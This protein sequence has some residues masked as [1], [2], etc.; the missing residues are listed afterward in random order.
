MAFLRCF[1]LFALLFPLHAY[2]QWTVAPGPS[3]AGSLFKTAFP[4]ATTGFLAA[5]NGD[6]FRTANGGASWSQ[7]YNEGMVTGSDSYYF[8]DIQFLSEQTGFAV[9]IDYWTGDFLILKTTNGGTSWSPF[10]YEFGLFIGWCNAVDFTDT[11]NGYVVGDFGLFFRTSNG[12]ATWTVTQTPVFSNLKAVDFVDSQNGFALS[13]D[14]HLLKTTNGGTS[15]Q[16]YYPQ[17][18][19]SF[20]RFQSA[21]LGFASGDGLFRTT[22]GGISW[23][24]MQSDIPF[25][26][27]DLEF[28]STTSAVALWNGNF[29][30]TN[31]ACQTWHLQQNTLSLPG[32]DD[33][34]GLYD[35]D[36]SSSTAGWA[37]GYKNVG[38]VVSALVMKTA[39]G[40]GIALNMNLSASYLPCPGSYP[41][42]A[43]ATVLGGTATLQW[44]IDGQPT[45][46]GAPTEILNGPWDSGYRAV[47]VDATQGNNTVSLEKYVQVEY[48]PTDN[49]AWIFNFFQNACIGDQV[50]LY[51]NFVSQD[52]LQLTLNGVVVDGPRAMTGNSQDNLRTSPLATDTSVFVLEIITPCGPV[53]LREIR[54]PARPL[55]DQS[56]P[57]YTEDPLTRCSTGNYTTITVGNTT[58][59]YYFRLFQDGQLVG[60]WPTSGGWGTTEIISG[61]FD[62]TAVFTVSATNQYGCVAFLHDSVVVQV[63][64]PEARFGINGANLPFGTPVGVNFEGKEATHLEW[65]FGPGA[66]PA[67]FSGGTPPAVQYSPGT[68]KSVISLAVEGPLGCRDTFERAIGFYTPGVPSQYWA[69]ESDLASQQQALILGQ[70]MTV[71]SQGNIYLDGSTDQVLSDPDGFGTLVASRAGAPAY[72]RE[73]TAGIFKYD[74]TGV[75]LWYLDVEG[76]QYGF[77]DLETTPDDQ[78]VMPF[79]HGSS[80]FLPSTDQKRVPFRDL[81]GTALCKYDQQ[82]RLLWTA[83]SRGCGQYGGAYA[84]DVEIDASGNIYML[85]DAS[86]NFGQ[87]CADFYSV[88]SSSP[89]FSVQLGSYV[90]KL[91]GNGKYLWVKSLGNSFSGAA[92]QTDGDGNILICGSGNAALIKL[93]PAGEIL[94]NLS[95][96]PGDNIV[97]NILNL[98]TDPSGNT[99]LAGLFRN[100][101]GFPGLPVITLGWPT[102]PTDYD[103]FVLKVN[104]DGNP[105]WLKAGVTTDW[106]ENT[107][108]QYRNG[109]VFVYG[110]FGQGSFQWDGFTCQ[111]RSWRNVIL[112]QLDAWQGDYEANLLIDEPN[113]DDSSP[114]ANWYACYGRSMQ[115]DAAGRIHLLGR[116]GY[117]ASFGNTDLSAP[118]WLYLAKMA[119][120]FVA[121][122]AEQQSRQIGGK[123]FPNPSAVG[124]FMQIE[125]EEATQGE[126]TL[127]DVTGRIVAQPLKVALQS[128][129]NRLELP[130]N[131]PAGVYQAEFQSENGY[132][133][134][135]PWIRK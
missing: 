120:M 5:D 94:W 19:F 110:S 40:G 126:F 34:A 123:I 101:V 43:N 3:G 135:L 58:P 59:E 1:T 64:R 27:R 62:S 78:L 118:G 65:S 28:L 73:E 104:P 47:R 6:I 14:N 109:S 33:T 45:G 80:G 15:W 100:E 134:T 95:V 60:S 103:L 83:W 22:D 117:S 7:V 115:V 35:F 92:L 2:S 93:N 114:V 37:V 77:R 91:D 17:Q 44:Y 70:N 30:R 52:L 85:G 48:A 90:A 111:G 102:H 39:N 128:G 63:E 84:R 116:T 23:E 9:G 50:V 112:L 66:N 29:Y 13:V 72:L 125:T 24:R 124:G 11:Q 105:V 46:M 129:I 108:I 8:R 127:S 86:G 98:D 133:L 10:N 106:S 20:I 113:P 55:P 97:I 54:V 42:T 61:Y 18:D 75:L 76:F 68:E 31:D 16:V 82:G 71:S 12:G 53:P 131:L 67:T 88:G 36:M 69:Q 89:D 132:R 87:E 99:Y 74:P 26:P 121:G 4:S 130:D 96:L 21:Q 56:L 57:V 38:G 119:P 41:L 25:G 51:P 107:A 49:Q 122:A 79:T 32:P 81:R